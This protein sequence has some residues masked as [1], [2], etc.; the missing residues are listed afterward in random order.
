MWQLLRDQYGEEARKCC[1]RAAEQ[2]RIQLVA[3]IASASIA[4][5]RE[6]EPACSMVM[7]HGHMVMQQCMAA[8]TDTRECVCWQ[9]CASATEEN[10]RRMRNVHQHGRAS[11]MQ[12]AEALQGRG[13]VATTELVT[14]ANDWWGI[15][16][17][18]RVSRAPL[19]GGKTWR[20]PRCN[21]SRR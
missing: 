6:G 10:S 20:P 8:Q 14:V 18:F 21:T 4:N 17:G 12:G 16:A 1:G 9:H 3:N 2:V 19:L 7:Q 11:A 13:A 5:A 15:E